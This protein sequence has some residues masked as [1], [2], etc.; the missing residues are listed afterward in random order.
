MRLDPAK[1]SPAAYHAM[2]G[3][4]SFVNKSSKV[5]VSLLD[6]IKMRASQ[7]N[8]CAF[9]IDMHSK[10][11]R[12]NGETEQRLYAL[13]AWR[14]TTFFTNRER[15]ALAWTEALTLITEGRAPDE[16]YA[17]V[18]KEFGEE[19]LV[20]LSVAII[21]INSWN[22]LAIGE[23]RRHIPSEIGSTI[24]EHLGQEELSPRE[25]SV[26]RLIRDSQKTEFSPHSQDASRER[27]TYV[28][29]KEA[30][31][32]ALAIRLSMWRHLRDINREAKARNSSVLICHFRAG[33]LTTIV[34]IL[35]HLGRL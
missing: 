21:T 1:V 8:G 10:D 6:L 19:D 35:L 2:L 15:A 23:G 32:V 18:R 4:E 28:R 31:D 33:S 30:E 25:T 3:L 12:V 11:A 27:S 5:E 17:E 14:E 22:R 29:R 7:I 13:S 9:S 34:A 20:N 16:V 24:A 26:L